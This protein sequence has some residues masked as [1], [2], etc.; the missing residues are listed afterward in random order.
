[1]LT[2][3]QALKKIL[4]NVKHLPPV[5][6]ALDDA[7]GKV[8]AEKAV[9]R[10]DLPFADN[11]AMDG[12]TF[13][14]SDQKTGEG[15]KVCNTIYA[16]DYSQEAVG[17]KEAVRIMT[18]APIPPGC[19]TV[20]PIEDVEERGDFVHLNK[21]V[22]R[23]QHVRLKGEEVVCGESIVA[24][25]TLLHAGDIGLLSAA[26]V[27]R[28]KI[29]P[30]PKIAILSTGN[31]LV[32]LGDPLQPGQIVNSNLHLLQARLKELGYETVTL[33]VARDDRDDL[34]RYMQEGLRADVLITTGGVS[35]GDRDHVQEVLDQLGFKL[36]FWKVAIKPGKPVLFGQIDQKTIFGLPGNPAAAAATF[37]LFVRPALGRLSGHPAP[38]HPVL[39]AKLTEDVHDAGE[40]QAF[41]WGELTENSTGR[42]CF[43]PSRHQGSNRNR[44]VQSAGA[45]LS[46]PT[47]IGT[48]TAGTEVEVMVLRLPGR[49]QI[50]IV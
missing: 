10:W 48:I 49:Q 16:G 33:G 30:T 41:L 15:L 13:T 24:A 43:T 3:T 21:P 39:R 19:D 14:W 36:G 42:Y 23:G 2:Y 8:M 47:G 6:C 46:V 9:A 26:G 27:D 4:S 28:V 45:L 34:L 31:E 7:V 44:A 38:L 29:H 40:R 22:K 20:V 12:F 18:G 1:M 35:I 5:E 37:E 25:G 17:R 50:G 32:N 11:S